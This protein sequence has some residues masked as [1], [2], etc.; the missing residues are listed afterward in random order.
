[1]YQQVTLI[2][3]LGRDPEMRYTAAGDAVTN[4]TLAVNRRWT[5]DD[6]QSQEKT[7]WFH[8]TFWRRQAEFANQYLGKGKRVLIVG[9]IDGARPYTD[10]DGNPRASIDI[11][12]R[13]IRILESRHHDQE[14]DVALAQSAEINNGL[15][16]EEPIPF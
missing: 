13:E 10:R 5:R 12:G 7:N 2:G 15:V 8:V 1:M 6:G 16:S 4:I 11:Q 3:Y 14:A 9:E